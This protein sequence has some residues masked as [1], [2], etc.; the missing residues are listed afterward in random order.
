MC[1]ADL[2]STA[3]EFEN[4]NY[5]YVTKTRL[6]A[7]RIIWKYLKAINLDYDM[8][9]QA[10]ESELTLTMP[11]RS[12]I[13]TDGADNESI[14]EKY[15]GIPWHKVFID[16]GQAF[17][18][19][20]EKFINEVLSPRLVDWDGSLTVMGTPNAARA[21]VFFRA[22][23]KEKGFREYENFHWTLHDNPW[24]EKNAGKPVAQIIAEECQRRGVTQDDASIQREFFGTWV[25]DCHS[26]VYDFDLGRNC[27]TDLPTGI[28][29]QYVLGVDLGWED[30]DAL[31]VWAYSFESPFIYLVDE[32]K[33][34]KLT[35]TALAEKIRSLEERFPFVQRVI[36]TGGLGKKVAE[37]IRMRY[38]IVLKPA[39]KQEK[40]A[41]IQLMN[42]D[43]RRGF[44]KV[45]PG[46]KL[47]EEWTLLQWDRN[48]TPPREDQRCENHL[49]DA[50]LYAWREAKH[51]NYEEKAPEPGIYTEAY[52]DREA[53]RDAEEIQA[54]RS[55]EW[56]E[57]TDG[58]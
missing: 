21:G 16:E 41:Y 13:Y 4:R 52:L 30:A 24:I 46:A 33:Q 26:R 44:I 31:T 15:R 6:N 23:N 51:Y 11:T 56:W 29:W 58:L 12:T 43:L 39:E 14:I 3:S 40:L 34:S 5:L 9:G 10:N 50:A 54:K 8:G 2:V 48:V 28:P 57:R 49:S 37:E 18:E 17:P 55:R 20:L 7:K 53:K 38:G 36:D 47:L 27:Y 19:Y 25:E 42:D 22:C 32:F 1:A 35:I 45:R